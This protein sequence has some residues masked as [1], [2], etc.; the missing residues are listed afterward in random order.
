MPRKEI[1]CVV[2]ELCGVSFKTA[3]NHFDYLIRS[4]QL[5]ELKKD[6]RV[7]T[8]QVTTTNRTAVTTEKLLRTHMSQEEGEFEFVFLYFD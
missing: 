3:E 7:V 6:G 4:K 8:A 5:P 1:I 2:A